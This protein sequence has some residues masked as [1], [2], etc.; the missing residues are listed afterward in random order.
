[1][2]KGFNFVKYLWIAF[3]A[4]GPGRYSTAIQYNNIN[5]NYNH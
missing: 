1:M 3:W 4:K 2:S 5:A